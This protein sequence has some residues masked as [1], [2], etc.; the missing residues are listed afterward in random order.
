MTEVLNDEQTTCPVH[1]T[2]DASAEQSCP[3]DAGRSPGSQFSEDGYETDAEGVK[4]PTS[5]SP[6]VRTR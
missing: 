5:T 3:A 6:S 4:P 1:A 2:D